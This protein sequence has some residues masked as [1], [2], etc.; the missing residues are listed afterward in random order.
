MSRILAPYLGQS[1]LERKIGGLGEQRL[2]LMWWKFWG[3]VG[4]CFVVLLVCVFRGGKKETKLRFWGGS[5][6]RKMKMYIQTYSYKKRRSLGLDTLILFWEMTSSSIAV[7]H[8]WWTAFGIFWM[9]FLGQILTPMNPSATTWCVSRSGGMHRESSGD[10]SGSWKS[11][12]EDLFLNGKFFIPL[13]LNTCFF[14][15]SFFFE[16]LLEPPAPF[17]NDWSS[18]SSWWSI[19]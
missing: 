6:G 15:V 18:W 2:L 3:W 7:Y 19:A 11:P 10:R 14:V 16:D 4:E 8:F 5:K 12:V 13:V 9:F 17:E 1:L